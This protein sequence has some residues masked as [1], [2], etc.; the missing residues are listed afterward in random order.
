MISCASSKNLRTGQALVEL[1]VAIS[2]LVVGF[3]SITSL[4]SR[5]L[6]LNRVI[7]ENYTA[8]YLASEGI[9]VVKNILDANIIA[10]QPWN[11][12]FA[13]GDYE[14]DYR[15]TSLQLNQGRTLSFDPVSGYYT[16]GSATPT[17][18]IRTIN[19]DLVSADEVRVISTVSWISRGN[20]NFAVKLEDHF[21]NW[22]Q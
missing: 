21:F 2:V 14:L 18:F 16:Y 10:A 4:L 1:M 6:A 13:N 22:R 15:T 5:S 8:T 3:L 19:I 12:G 9:E 17:P 11:N 7:A 20:A